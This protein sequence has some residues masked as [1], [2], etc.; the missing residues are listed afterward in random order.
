MV[1]SYFQQTRPECR[2][3]SNITTG[4][5]KKIDC[6]SVHGVC[7]HC[8]TVFEAMGCYFHYCPSQEFRPSLTDNK[9]MRGIKMRERD[10]MRKDYIQQKGCKI[11][12]MWECNWW[13]LYRTIAAVR[14]HL[15]ANFPMKRLTVQLPK[16]YLTQSL[17]N[18]LRLH[19]SSLKMSIE[20]KSLSDSSFCN[21]L[22]PECWSFIISSSTSF[23]IPK[24]WRAWNG[25]RLSMCSSFGRELG[26]YYSPREM[27]RMGSN[28]YARLYR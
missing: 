19:L 12:E 26:R 23:A 22:R 7:N 21:M 2:I 16:S 14:N 25:Y 28:T 5:Q 9:I 13:E 4:R 3:E 27:K 10:Q 18:F 8:N 6:F 15:Q 17:I 1:F 11:I 20:N 24:V